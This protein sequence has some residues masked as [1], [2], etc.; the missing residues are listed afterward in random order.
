MQDS[1]VIRPSNSSWSSPIVLVRKDGTQRFCVD[2][3]EVNSVTR[4]DKFPLPRVDNL[5]DQLGKTRYFPSLDLASGYWQIKVKPESRPKTAFV[6]HQGLYEFSVMPFRLTNAPSVF[7]RLMQ[8]V[9]LGL[10]PDNAPAFVSV[11]IDDILIY[12]RTLAE[13]MEHLRTV[14]NRL[15]EVSLKLKP[16]KCQFLQPEVDFLGHVITTNGF[17]TSQCNVDAISNFP[18]PQNVSEVRQFMGLASYYRRFIK[19]FAAIAQPLHALTRKGAGYDWTAECQQAFKELKLSLTQAPI[20]AYPS[21]EW[22]F[23]L[24]T[25][26]S[27][28]GIGAVLS[29]K[30]DDG[31]LHPV[32]FASRG[33]SAAEQNYSITDLETLAVVWAMSHFRAYLYGRRVTIY[34]DHMAVKAV[35]QN[36]N[37]SGR[38]ARWWIKV[39]GAGL[40]EVNIVYRAGKDNAAAD[41]LSRNPR[42]TAPVEGI[43]EGEVQVARVEVGSDGEFEVQV[44]R[45]EVG[46]DEEFGKVL[47]MDP[48][49]TSVPPEGSQLAREQRQDPDLLCLIEYLENNRLP[50]DTEKAKMIVVKSSQFTLMGGALYLLEKKSQRKRAV[51]PT[52]LRKQLISEVHGGPL[53]GHFSSNWIVKNLARSWWWKVMHEDVRTHCRSCPQCA[54]VS[55]ASRPGRPPLQPIP[56]SRPFQ[57]FGVDVMDLPLTERGHKHVVVFQ[58]FLTKWPVVIPIPDQKTIRI[59]RL[60]VEEIIPVFGVPEALLSDRGTNLLSF[61][62]RD[63]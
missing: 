56:V 6:T 19:D 26:A 21:F 31:R 53:V 47:Q 45:V 8:R 50:E 36:P 52:H 46:S 4:K 49:S 7:Q 24:E 13:H 60:L 55:G 27:I 29:Q 51:V 20:L 32:A 15:I 10:N 61:L 34:T 18:V 37:T 28:R 33:L 57:I 54:I 42:Q 2:Y 59:V 30:Q 43:A 9:L 16:S 12:S 58:D 25:D 38:H 14:L 22:D 39:H 11:Y 3:R 40:K 62:M 1:G 35:L 17:K 48:E 5:L 23:T 44:A 41:A 63:V